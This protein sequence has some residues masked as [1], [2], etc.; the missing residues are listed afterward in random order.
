MFLLGE[1]WRRGRHQ[2][3]LVASFELFG[4]PAATPQPAG[5]LSQTLF[6]AGMRVVFRAVHS[7]ENLEAARR[8]VVHDKFSARLQH[9]PHFLQ[10]AERMLQM[11]KRVHADHRVEAAI[12]PGQLLGIVDDDANPAARGRLTDAQLRQP[13]LIR[14]Q[15]S[16]VMRS[17]CLARS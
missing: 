10:H 16:V 7:V 5:E 8:E 4:F 17:A 9:A 3:F 11:V 2:D 1:N 15:V 13:L 14:V 12:H 6:Q